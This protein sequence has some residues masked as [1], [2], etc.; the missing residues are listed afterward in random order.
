MTEYTATVEHDGTTYTATKNV[1]DI[2]A[3][4]HDWGEDGHCTICDAV[5]PGFTPEIIQGDKATWTKGDGQ[6]LS[7]TS[8][9][10]YA[11]FQEVRVDGQILDPV[12]YTAERGST[13]VTLKAAYL[14]SL[15]P[16]EHTLDIVSSTGIATATFTITAKETQQPADG[17]QTPSDTQQPAKPADTDRT[18]AKSAG[19]GGQL[20]RGCSDIMPAVATLAILMASG[21][22]LGTFVL[23]RG[24]R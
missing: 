17:A 22:V 11:D 19:D 1:A 14:E 9:A 5:K 15:D 20:S 18:P 10:A 13:I 2:P 4:G 23:R 8:N 6:P 21:L 24:R 7:F 3:T 16:G 12:H